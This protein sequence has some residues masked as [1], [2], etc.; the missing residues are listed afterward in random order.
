MNPAAIKLIFAQ[1]NRHPSSFR[2]KN[3]DTL[4]IHNA[5]V[6]DNMEKDI[7]TCRYGDF[8]KKTSK[9][10][11]AFKENESNKKMFITL[12]YSIFKMLMRRWKNS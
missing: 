10:N 2:K 6:H 7:F 5:N 3:M 9:P 4:N 8:L 11:T 12:K 1:A